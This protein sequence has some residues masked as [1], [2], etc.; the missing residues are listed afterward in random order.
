MLLLFISYMVYGTPGELPVI[1]IKV[2]SAPF[3][4]I[5]RAISQLYYGIHSIIIFIHALMIG[6]CYEISIPSTIY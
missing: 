4:F 2:M 1:S 5:Y 3:G 6:L